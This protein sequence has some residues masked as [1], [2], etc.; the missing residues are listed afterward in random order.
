MWHDLNTARL[1][2]YMDASMRVHIRL[3]MPNLSFRALEYAHTHTHAHTHAHTHT[4]AKHVAEFLYPHYTGTLTNLPR[5][6]LA[7]YMY[8]VKHEQ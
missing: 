2:F 4:K 6:E 7:S 5:V 8:R 1:A 3:M